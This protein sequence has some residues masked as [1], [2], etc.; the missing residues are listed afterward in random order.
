MLSHIACPVT[1]SEPILEIV[2]FLSLDILKSQLQTLV[3]VGELPT[4]CLS[5]ITSKACNSY[6]GALTERDSVAWPLHFNEKPVWFAL[7]ECLFCWA[8]LTG[9]LGEPFS[10]SAFTIL[11]VIVILNLVVRREQ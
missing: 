10:F 11:I 8:F 5:K 4:S 6:G 9:S 3:K 2:L 7:L 1:Q